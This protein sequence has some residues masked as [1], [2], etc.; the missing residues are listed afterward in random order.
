MSQVRFDGRVA[1]VTG[2]GGGLGRTYA[3]DLASR[4]AC[5]VVNDLGC[6]FDGKGSSKEMADK[7]VA[8]IRAAGG[9]AVASYDSVATPAGGEAI[10]AKALETFGRVDVLINNAGTLRNAPVDQLPDSTL[11]TML[12]VHLKGRI[13]RNATGDAGDEATQVRSHPVRIVGRRHA[14][15]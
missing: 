8:E 6:T 1:I 14:R 13:L 2:S 11:D 10:V 15:Q 9:K 4:G 7:V 3:L 12:E 5:V